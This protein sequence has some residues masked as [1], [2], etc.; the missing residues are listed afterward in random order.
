MSD[1]YPRSADGAWLKPRH[2]GF[3]LMCCDCS[4]VHVMNLRVLRGQVYMQFTRNKRATAAARR[5]RKTK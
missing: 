5:K 2:R 1:R 4:L 3:R